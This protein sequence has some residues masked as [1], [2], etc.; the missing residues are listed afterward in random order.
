M[1]SDGQ[2]SLQLAVWSSGLIPA[3]HAGH[4]DD[5]CL[6]AFLSDLPSVT[7]S[8]TFSGDHTRPDWSLFAVPESPFPSLAAFQASPWTQHPRSLPR[9]FCSSRKSEGR[10]CGQGGGGSWLSPFTRPDLVPLICN[11]QVPHPRVEAP[12]SSGLQSF[13]SWPLSPKG[14]SKSLLE[15]HP[16]GVSLSGSLKQC[17]HSG[18]FIWTTC[19]EFGFCWTLGNRLTK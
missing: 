3:T 4:A 13:L 6:A 5:Q 8:V 9:C 16:N 7:L 11:G 1:T 15:Q 18:L 2:W 19:N 14:S 10:R 12:A 17:F